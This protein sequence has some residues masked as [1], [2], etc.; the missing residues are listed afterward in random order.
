MDSEH[1]KEKYGHFYDQCALDEMTGVIGSKCPYITNKYKVDEKQICE[2]IKH[3]T[4][5]KYR[6]MNYCFRNQKYQELRE[7]MNQKYK[8]EQWNIELICHFMRACAHCKCYEII[9]EYKEKIRGYIDREYEQKEWDIRTIFMIMEAC[10]HC[11]SYEILKEF[12]APKIKDTRNAYRY[13]QTLNFYKK[14]F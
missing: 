5:H 13:N 4:F 12:K 6:Y 3:E 11:N 14:E 8:H 9:E 2:K 1:F 10:T 7:H